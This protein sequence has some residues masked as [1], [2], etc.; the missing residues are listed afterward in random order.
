MVS[1]ADLYSAAD[2]DTVLAL[3]THKV[4]RAARKQSVGEARLLLRD[5][6]AAFAGNYHRNAY[7]RASVEQLAQLPV[8]RYALVLLLVRPA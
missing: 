7:M 1:P 8:R 2:A 4:T 3:L 6:L 5:W